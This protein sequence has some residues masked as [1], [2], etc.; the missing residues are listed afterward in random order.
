MFPFSIFIYSCFFYNFHF[1]ILYFQ[2]PSTSRIHFIF[3]FRLNFLFIFVCCF[4]QFQDAFCL[5]CVIPLKSHA[6][7]KYT[8]ASYRV[9]FF[10]KQN[11]SNM[12]T[13]NAMHCK[14]IALVVVL[15]C[16]ASLLVCTSFWC[17]KYPITICF[18]EKFLIKTGTISLI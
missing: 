8:C 5:F 6:V 16:S 10:R 17:K 11:P 1:E 7:L 14:V 12:S 15:F 2:F 18:S 3:P 4:Y 13:K 9:L